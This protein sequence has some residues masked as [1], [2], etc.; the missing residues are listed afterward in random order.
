[1]CHKHSTQTTSDFIHFDH[2][3]AQFSRVYSKF[4]RASERAQIDTQAESSVRLLRSLCLIITNQV[5][6][7][8]SKSDR[9]LSCT[10]QV[11]HRV[12]ASD[13]LR[14]RVPH[15]NSAKTLAQ[16]TVCRAGSLFSLTEFTLNK[17]DNN[18]LLV[19]WRP[20][21]RRRGVTRTPSSWFMVVGVGQ[22]RAPPPPQPPQPPP[23]PSI[24][25][26]SRGGIKE[27][28]RGRVQ[29]H[30]RSLRICCIEYLHIPVWIDA[31]GLLRGRGH[32]A[33]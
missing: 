29:L 7:P 20:L 3:R 10:S 26:T 27:Y 21:W 11:T 19:R 4:E 17:F 25:I 18:N 16:L 30:G 6:K 1:M 22:C 15:T 2:S 32:N 24:S 8:V 33:R 9:L 28:V 13:Q 12:P 23:Q 14:A 5:A 31:R